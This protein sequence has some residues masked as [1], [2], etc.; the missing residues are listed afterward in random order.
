MTELFRFLGIKF[1]V[2]CNEQLP[3]QVHIENEDGTARFE[4]NPLKLIENNGIK[5]KEIYRAEN[6][7]EENTEVIVNHCKDHFNKSK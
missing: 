4:V 2:A 6:I 1:F 3:I 5:N 7:I